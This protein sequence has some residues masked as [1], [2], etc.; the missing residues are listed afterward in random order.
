MRHSPRDLRSRLRAALFATSTVLA[1]GGPVAG[2]GGGAADD[3]AMA[4]AAEAGEGAGADL[5][6]GSERTAWAAVGRTEDAPS[7]PGGRARAGTILRS[8]TA[9][10]ERLEQAESGRVV[11]VEVEC[12][13][14][15]AVE[16]ALAIAFGMQA[17]RDLPTSAPFVVR[18]ADAHLGAL[19][20]DRLVEMGVPKVLLVVP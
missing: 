4:A 20:A 15:P 9:T 1:A 10:A 13:G 7:S 6:P 18:A 11:Y 2:C 5:A 12:C 19:A 8:S 14:A 16:Q 17:A 3:T